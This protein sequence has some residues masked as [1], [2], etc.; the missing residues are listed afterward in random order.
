MRTSFEEQVSWV[1]AA[2]GIRNEIS[3]EYGDWPRL[4]EIF[5]RRN[6]FTHTNGIVNDRYLKKS[7]KLKFEGYENLSKG[8]ELLANPKYFRAALE[9]ICD[10][11]IKIT[12]VCW[13]KI[14]KGSERAADDAL[15]DFGFELIQRGRYNLAIKILEFFFSLKGKKDEERRL[16]C[17]VNLANA[18]KL[19]GD[20][21]KAQKLLDQEDWSVVNDTFRISVAA[22]QGRCEEVVRLM[23]KMGAGC[24]FGERAYEEWPIFFHVRDQPEFRVAFE[25][26]FKH[27]YSPSPKKRRGILDVIEKSIWEETQTEG[28]VKRRSAKSGKLPKALPL[29]TQVPPA[30]GMKPAAE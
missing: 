17:L 9:Y 15:G 5:E 27:E 6:L 7:E 1:E 25:E 28:K 18:Y 13:R 10:F 4:V 23:R 14:E 30:S 24:D 19:N 22:V 12:Q 20:T 2:V 26:V 16:I 29:R 3:A 8:M 11:G 21:K